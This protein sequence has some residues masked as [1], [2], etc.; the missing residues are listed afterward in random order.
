MKLFADLHLHSSMD[1]T[2]LHKGVRFL[3]TPFQ[4]I[5]RAVTLGIEVLAFTHHAIR[6]DLNDI[7]YYAKEHGVLLVPGEE[8]LVEDKHVLLYNFPPAHIFS[9][10]ELQ[11][12]HS[13]ETM[14]VAPH[15]FFPGKFSLHQ[16]LLDH[17]DLFDAV[18][19]CHCYL[20]W[21][22]FN[23]KACRIAD[24]Y[25]LPLIGNSD[26][27]ALW[28]MGTTYSEIEVAEKT[29]SAVIDAVKNGRV[30]VITRPLKYREV[31]KIFQNVAGTFFSSS[32]PGKKF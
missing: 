9:F 2:D 19:Y 17:V 28:Q 10:D 13:S 12:L 18:E 4:L 7:D 15:P 3:P 16:K 25:H 29:V 23:K 20:P 6:F 32:H 11:V 14:I 8:G 31:L 27:H 26:A 1:W 21:L 24:Q 30:R 5:D 22:N